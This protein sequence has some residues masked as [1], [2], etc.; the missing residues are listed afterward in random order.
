MPFADGVSMV[1]TPRKTITKMVSAVNS[2]LLLHIKYLHLQ[3]VPRFFLRI[4]LAKNCQNA[5]NTKLELL[6]GHHN[7]RTQILH[8]GKREQQI[9]H[10]EG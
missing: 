4:V 9:R 6:T 3:R 5:P 7:I 1:Y 10:G 8:M 2:T